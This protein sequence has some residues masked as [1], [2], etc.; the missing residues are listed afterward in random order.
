MKNGILII[1]LLALAIVSYSAGPCFT[2]KDGVIQYSPDH[3]LAGQLIK[4]GFDEFGYNYQ[5][6]L[7]N[8]CYANVYLGGAGFPAYTGDDASYFALNYFV[9]NSDKIAAVQTHWAWPYRDIALSM[10][11]NDAWIANTD[12]DDDGK[13]D[14]HFGY[15]SYIGSGAWETNHMSGTYLGLDGKEYHWT[16]F[17]KIVAVPIDAVKVAGIWY[18]PD[19]EEIGP[20]IWG[21]FAVIE[22]ILNDP[23]TGDHGVLYKSPARAGF[24]GWDR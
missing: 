13:L 12:N 1:S 9:I 7:F 24:G 22:E 14:R 5:A 21:E 20:D 23:G 10:K 4:P 16:N 11:W 17:V 2:L 3:Y 15:A 19:G 6:H 18:R 8:G